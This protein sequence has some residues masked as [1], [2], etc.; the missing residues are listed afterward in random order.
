[1]TTINFETVDCC[2]CGIIFQVPEDFDQAREDDGREFY[3]PNGHSQHYTNCPEDKIQ[4]LE[5]KNTELQRQVRQLKCR[6]MG[7]V[8]FKERIKMWWK[9]GL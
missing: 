3:C 1:M 4:V 9:G 6:L 5:A 2:E 8:G 7:Q